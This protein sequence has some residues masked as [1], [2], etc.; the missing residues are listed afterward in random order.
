M[1]P[2]WAEILWWAFL[3]AVIPLTVATV[4]ANNHE[5]RV[6]LAAAPIYWIITP[7]FVSAFLGVVAY[8]IVRSQASRLMLALLANGTW[9]ALQL[10]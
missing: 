3:G 10:W 5:R 2:W 1:I 9:S 6:A 4:R 7:S 8:F